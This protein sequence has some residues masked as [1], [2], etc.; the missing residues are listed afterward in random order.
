[1]MYSI[2]VIAEDTDSISTKRCSNANFP[3]H[4]SYYEQGNFNVYNITNSPFRSLRSKTMMYITL[5]YYEQED[6]VSTIILRTFH[7]VRYVQNYSFSICTCTTLS[8]YEQGRYSVVVLLRT[9]YSICYSYMQIHVPKW[10]V[11]T[12]YTHLS[13]NI[14]PAQYTYFSVL[15]T[16]A[17]RHK[18]CWAGGALS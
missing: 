1:M 14:S 11:V 6:F 2:R 9:F 10:R 5:S 18:F 8:Y 15:Y 7:S 3:V 16:Y 13:T 12:H 4:L 17:R